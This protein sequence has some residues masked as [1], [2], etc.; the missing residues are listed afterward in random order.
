MTGIEHRERHTIK[1]AVHSFVTLF[2]C[3]NYQSTASISKDL[4]LLSRFILGAGIG[5]SRLLLRR[6]SSSDK[7]FSRFILERGS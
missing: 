1:Y 5:E 3:L 6:S 2:Y 4:L 7:S